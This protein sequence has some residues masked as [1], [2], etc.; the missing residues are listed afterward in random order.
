MDRLMKRE[1]MRHL[2]EKTEAF[3]IETMKPTYAEALRV[4][5]WDYDKADRAMKEMYGERRWNR[6]REEIWQWLDISTGELSNDCR[7]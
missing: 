7:R 5:S 6:N 4:Y 1:A 2:E 3:I